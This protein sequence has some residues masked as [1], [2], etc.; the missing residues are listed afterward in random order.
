MLMSAGQMRWKGMWIMS[1]EIYTYKNP[2]TLTAE[3]FWS[4]VSN[5]PYFCV[6]Q[7]TAS[8]LNNV[9]P[10]AFPLYRVSTI[11]RL[12]NALYK[13]WNSQTMEVIQYADIDNIIHNDLWTSDEQRKTN[14]YQSFIFN[15]EEVCESIRTMVELNVACEHINQELL[16]EDQRYIVE[17]Y[18]KIQRDPKKVKHF[19]LPETF[20]LEQIDEAIKAALYDRDLN[21]KPDVD[22]LNLDTI[23][24]HGVHQFSPLILRT[25]EQ[26]SKYKRV[27]L[28]FNYQKQYKKVYQTWVDIYQY[29]ETDIQMSQKGEFF[30]TDS[31]EIGYE[32]NVLA[33]CLGALCEGKRPVFPYHDKIKLI[34]F[35]SLTEFASY[36][37]HVYKGAISKSTG[38][39]ELKLMNEQFYAA[40]SSVN[41]IL[42]T[43]YPDQFGERDFL[44]YPVG[45]FFLA[46]VSM[47][48]TKENRLVIEDLNQLRECFCCNILSESRNGN[49][50]SIF[51]KMYSLFI[52]ATSIEEMTKRLDRVE[53]NKRRV[54]ENES[55]VH[56]T[57]SFYAVSTEEVQAL[58]KGLEELNAIAESLLLDFDRTPKNFSLFYNKVKQYLAKRLVEGK[59]DDEK[60]RDIIARVLEHLNTIESDDIT[61]SFEC[62]RITM[63]LYLQQEPEDDASARWIVRNFEQID[64]DI[65]RSYHDRNKIYH[66]ACI[67]D[68]DVNASEHNDFPWPLDSHFFTIAQEPIDWKYQVYVESA[69]EYKNFRRYALIYGLEFNRAKVKLS[70]ISKNGDFDNEPYYLLNLI[71]VKPIP[72]YMELPEDPSDEPMHLV[73]P[74]EIPAFDRI[75]C[76]RFRMCPYRFLLETFGDGNIVYKDSFLQ[77]RCFEAIIEDQAREILV[78]Y[79]NILHNVF[80]VVNDVMDRLERFFP[81]LTEAN[82]AD[83]RR[84]VCTNLQKEKCKVFPPRTD[85]QKQMAAF[86]IQFLMM[87]SKAEIDKVFGSVTQED[88]DQLSVDISSAEFMKSFQKGCQFCAEK[89]LCCQYYKFKK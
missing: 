13:N 45:R 25:I 52:G 31:S 77:Q 51:T 86:R 57:M 53:R 30:P 75:D 88:L 46:L 8:G 39:A 87:P 83:I 64:G 74:E 20:S 19:T 69:E 21:N 56:N 66:F 24:I 37:S 22:S 76:Y 35:H 33:D 62:L 41:E 67:S 36:V 23:V 71:G 3:N 63:P 65:L 7:T 81:F 49:L 55:I 43:Y 5:C 15:G 38:K 84:R 1:L 59:N 61:A 26:L 34:E 6:S 73:A 78:N 12:E 9:N 47:W 40:D 16:G 29:F 58:R 2:Y 50:G 28:I 32:G 4:D 70:Y 42:K 89:D 85:A 48:D 68:R 14:L 80:S 54:K 72:Y 10:V 44:D 18:K 27:V 82:K 60:F 17:L 11:Y 79:S